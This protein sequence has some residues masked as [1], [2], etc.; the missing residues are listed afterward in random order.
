MDKVYEPNARQIERACERIRARWTMA[1]LISRQVQV[2]SVAWEVPHP[3]RVEVR[4]CLPG[5]D[6]GTE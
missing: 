3:E 2:D 4:R 1:Q 5:E 6:G